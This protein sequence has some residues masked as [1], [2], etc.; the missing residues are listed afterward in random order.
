MFGLREIGVA[1]QGDVA[2]TRA[3]TQV[4]RTIE[5]LGGLL[6]ARAVAAAI[7]DVQR[8]ARIGQRHHQRMVPP[9]SFVIDIDAFLALAGRLH[10]RAIG[11]NHRLVKEGRRLF[12]PHTQPDRVERLHQS[13][14]RHRI[15]TTAKVTRR[16]RV[17]NPL[18]TERIQVDFVIPSQFQMIQARATGQQVVGNIQ[19]V[20]GFTVRQVPFEDW[21]ATD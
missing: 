2:K 20:V 21:D 19:H 15:E 6:V 1:T 5:I 9:L 13:P 8:L 7:D 10:H 14:D 12:L 3:A 18:D 16:S 11:L 4:H 17:R